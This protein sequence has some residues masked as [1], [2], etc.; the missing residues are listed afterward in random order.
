MP[1]AKGAALVVPKLLTVPSFDL[2]SVQVLDQSSPRYK[3]LNKY[4]TK[5]CLLGENCTRK[6]CFY[7]HSDGL[8]RRQQSVMSESKIELARKAIDEEMAEGIQIS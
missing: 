2:K 6:T 4:M 1:S 3:D 8:I 7:A 5:M